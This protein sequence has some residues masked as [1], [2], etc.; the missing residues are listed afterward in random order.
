VR[1]SKGLA[2]G[3]R[4]RLRL[5]GTHPVHAFIDFERLDAEAPRK[6]ARLRRKQAWARDLRDR[7][8]E[9]FDAVVTGVTS[10]ATWLR[11]D[12]S[13]IEGRL[14][15]GVRSVTVGDRL[16]VLLLSADPERGFIDF[17]RET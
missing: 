1:G 8:G 7:V 12:P 4:I 6:E 13:G 15:R 10:R 16:G 11:L 9:R 5:V 14:V 2:V 17:A 3:Q